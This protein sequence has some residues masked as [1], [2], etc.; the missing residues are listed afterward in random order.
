[1]EIGTWKGKRA[2]QIIGHAAQYNSVN[3]ISYF[4]FDLFEKIDLNVYKLEIS[5]MPPTEREVFDF[6]STT[7]ATIKL[8]AGYTQE[9]LTD[10]SSKLPKMDLVFIDG[11]HSSQTVLNDWVAVQ[12]LMDENTVVIFDDYWHNRKDGPKVVIDKIDKSNYKVEFLPEVDVFFNPDFGKLVISLV[13]VTI[14]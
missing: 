7:N 5:K 6:L 9:T 2:K 1:M 14:K 10:I 13:K 11:G 12:R 8:Y 4:G 3:T